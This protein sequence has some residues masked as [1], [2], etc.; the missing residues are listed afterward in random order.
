MFD[1]A[2]RKDVYSERQ[3]QLRWQVKC[4]ED[5][6]TAEFCSHVLGDREEAERLYQVQ[7]HLRRCILFDILI[8]YLAHLLENSLKNN[9]SCNMYI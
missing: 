8:I 4:G 3:N 6:V 9:Y 1:V 2:I 7:F 5:P